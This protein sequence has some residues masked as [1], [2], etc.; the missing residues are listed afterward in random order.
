MSRAQDARNEVPAAFI[1]WDAQ[2]P[3]QF[4]DC[5]GRIQETQRAAGGALLLGRA[6]GVAECGGRGAQRLRLPGR[7]GLHYVELQRV[8][9]QS[10]IL[11]LRA[12]APAYPATGD[13]QR[14]VPRLIERDPLVQVLAHGLRIGGERLIAL[15]QVL[16][17]GLRIGGE[18][19]IAP[20][21]SPTDETAID[22]ALVVVVQ[23][24]AA[25]RTNVEL[26]HVQPAAA[27][28]AA[29]AH[30]VAAARGAE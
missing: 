25:W 10:E 26:L 6:G 1:A 15:V 21:Q 18:R 23:R 19:L 30:L 16:A 29:G 7:A 17:H 13:I 14:I 20:T 2:L 27:I 24:V 12:V 8:R 4:A 22:S 5:V 11:E 9:A 28:V 3:R